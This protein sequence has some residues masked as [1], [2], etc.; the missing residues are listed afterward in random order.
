[1]DQAFL[2]REKE[3]FKLNA[4]LNSKAKKFST[5]SNKS[6]VK[7]VQIHTAN[8]NLNYYDE[9][10]A[11]SQ[12]EFQDEES[13]SCKKINISN[14]P[15]KKN[16]EIIYPL[17]N[18][19]I[20]RGSRDHNTSDILILMPGGLTVADGKAEN[21][22]SF[23]NDNISVDFISEAVSGQSFKN[24]SLLTRYSDDTSAVAPTEKIIEH[25]SPSITNIPVPRTIEKKNI[26]N[27]GLL[28]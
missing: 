2:E 7:P 18:R 13:L 4:K 21:A 16:H 12:K 28:K 9:S 11:I 8:S 26:S 14:Q 25:Q 19:H 23:A 6:L 22:D 20:V 10:L 3:L 15:P 27:D 24:E 5:T 17:F 1:M